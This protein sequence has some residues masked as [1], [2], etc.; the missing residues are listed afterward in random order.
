MTEGCIKTYITI[1]G[2]ISIS[3]DGEGNIDGLYLPS[4][5]L[6]ILRDHESD[7]INEA[8]VQLNE[9]LAGKRKEFDLPLKY[10]GTEF[11]EKV[12]DALQNIPYGELISYSGIAKVIGKENAYRAV[13]TACGSNPLPIFIPCH[14]VIGSDGSIDKYAGGAALKKKLIDIERD[15]S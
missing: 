14:R 1:V 15:G 12:W 6:P 3:E 11:Q 5:N 4:F 2:T 9:Y 7:A 13:G 10:E 8:Y